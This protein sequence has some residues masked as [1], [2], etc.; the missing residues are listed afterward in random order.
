LS[1]FCAPPN[2]QTAA[3]ALGSSFLQDE[4]NQM[5]RI[6]SSA[7][8]AACVALSAPLAAQSKAQST[9]DGAMD[10]ASQQEPKKPATRTRHSTKRTADAR[11]C[12][13]F[14]TNVEITRCAEKYL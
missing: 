2:I 13:Q 5:K 8:L 14:T 11:A 9:G 3:I 7:V 1:C 4:E 12:L 6:A 10:A